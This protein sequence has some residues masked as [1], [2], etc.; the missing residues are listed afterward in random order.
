MEKRTYYRIEYG[1]LPKK[2]VALKNN[3]ITLKLTDYENETKTLKLSFS[4]STKANLDTF[5]YI[6]NKGL[7]AYQG[8][9]L[10]EVNFI[11]RLC[12]TDFD[13]L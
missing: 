11:Y 12:E 3:T 13:R 6:L 10:K 9:S 1:Y 5:L 4:F 8:L 2:S 7:K